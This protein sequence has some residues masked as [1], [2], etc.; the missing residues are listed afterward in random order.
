MIHTAASAQVER[1]NFCQQVI[2][3]RIQ[4]GLADPATIFDDVTMVKSQDLQNADG[5]LA[6]FPCQAR[7]SWNVASVQ[8]LRCQ[9]LHR[10]LLTRASAWLEPR[11]PWWTVG[12]HW[13]KNHLGCGMNQ[14]RLDVRWH[15]NMLSIFKYK[16]C[17]IHLAPFSKHR[18]FSTLHSAW[19]LVVW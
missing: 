10:F 7:P 1:S 4:D 14:L 19:L 16:H 3:A 11:C 15:L 6:G 2:R 9:F 5:L 12:A 18:G 17:N 8:T 13:C